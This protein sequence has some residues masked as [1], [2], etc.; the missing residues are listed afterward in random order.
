[1]PRALLPPYVH[2]G[3]VRGRRRPRDR[4]PAAPPRGRLPPLGRR[5]RRGDLPPRE[6]TA[7]GAPPV[8]APRP[9]AVSPRRLALGPPLL[10]ARAVRAPPRRQAHRGRAWGPHRPRLRALRGPVRRTARP[11][12]APAGVLSGAVS[13]PITPG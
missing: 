2:V 10:A 4:C 13:R 8:R 11:G 7:G 3:A 1:P 5:P 12:Y 9:G 6:A